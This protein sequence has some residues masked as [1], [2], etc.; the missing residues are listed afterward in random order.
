MPFKKVLGSLAIVLAVSTQAQ[1]APFYVS[2]FTFELTGGAVFTSFITPGIPF[3]DAG[4]ILDV[5]VPG[6][7][8]VGTVLPGETF[9]ILFANT[10]I[11]SLLGID[12]LVD[13]NDPTAFPMFLDWVGPATSLTMTPVPRADD[14]PEPGTLALFGVGA[15]AILRRRLSA[16]PLRS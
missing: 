10:P 7:G 14:L 11:F 12:S 9:N 6:S 2:G 4:D 8:V 1:A 3:L 15:L 13:A 16:T 5:V